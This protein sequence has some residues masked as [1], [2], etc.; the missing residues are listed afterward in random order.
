MI[1][2]QILHKAGMGSNELDDLSS[3]ESGSLWAFGEDWWRQ[4]IGR[5]HQRRPRIDVYLN[6]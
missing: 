2:N 6:N 1:K 5:G 4:E 3:Q